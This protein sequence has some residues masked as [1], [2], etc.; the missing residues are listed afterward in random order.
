MGQKVKISDQ[1]RGILRAL[2]QDGAASL[3][4]IGARIGIDGIDGWKPDVVHAHDWQAGLVPVY[5]AQMSDHRPQTSRNAKTQ[6]HQR[7][8]RRQLIH[9]RD[10]NRQCAQGKDHQCHPD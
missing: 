4:E 8:G 10:D 7:P 1:E 5:M 3:A 2:Q 6:K 9:N